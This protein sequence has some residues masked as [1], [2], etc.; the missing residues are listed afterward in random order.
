MK[1]LFAFKPLITI[2]LGRK[3]ATLKT[4]IRLNKTQFFPTHKKFF[5]VNLV[6]LKLSP[7]SNQL[8]YLKARYGQVP[9]LTSSATDEPHYRRAPL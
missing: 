5:L 6:L 3:I 7:T 2:L 4:E 9:L 8:R 1:K